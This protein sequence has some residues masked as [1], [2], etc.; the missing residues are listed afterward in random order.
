LGHSGRSVVGHASRR[1]RHSDRN[2]ILRSTG[3]VPTTRRK[4]VVLV[5]AGISG[6]VSALSCR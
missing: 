6:L 5:L 2:L 3:S 1:K 4:A